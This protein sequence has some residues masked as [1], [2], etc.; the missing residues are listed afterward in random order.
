MLCACSGEHLPLDEMPQSPESLATRD[1]SLSGLSFKN[2]DG[3]SK[4]NDSQQL[5][6]VESALK[7]GLSLNYEEARALLGRLEYQRG[8]FNAALQVFQGIDIGTMRPKMVKAIAERTSLKRVRSKLDNLPVYIMSL[9]SV[10]LLLEALLLKSMSLQELGHFE[11][12]AAECKTILDIV[13]SAW[14]DG[15]PKEIGNE[16]KLKELFHRA[17]DLLPRLWKQ[18]GLL[19]EAIAAYRRAL[20]K[21]WDLSPQRSASLQKDLAISLLYGGAEV[22][23]LHLLQP[24]SIVSPKNNI[25]EAV[26][27]LFILMRKIASEEISGDPEIMNHLTFALSLSGCFESLATYVEQILPGILSRYER[28]YLL[29][30][31]YS[32]AG[33]NDA[34][35]NILRKTF[36]RSEMKKRDHFPSLLLGAKLCRTNPDLAEEGVEFARRAVA[37]ST[38]QHKNQHFI[39]VA[40]HLLGTCYGICSGSSRP[41]LERL[42]LEKES[43]NLLRFAENLVKNDPEIIYSIALVHAKQRNLG[44]ARDYAVRY[45]NMMA[46][47]SV[48][49]WK[50]LAL[51]ASAEQDMKEAEAIVDLSMDEAGKDQLELLRL[52]AV[53]QVAQEEFK[54]AVET[55]MSLLAAIEAQRKRRSWSTNFKHNET[56]QQLEMET[57]LE[58]ALIYSRLG[59]WNDSDICLNK[60]KSIQYFSPKAWHGTGNLLEARSLH[61]EALVAFSMSLSVD[62][63]Y[64]PSMVSTAAVLRMQGDR[65]LPMARSFLMNAVRIDPTNH[66]AWLHLGIVE[67]TEGSLQ[68]AADCFQAAYELKQSSPVMSFL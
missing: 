53:L 2:G 45:L 44:M 40:S 34:A 59:L 43:L 3:E 7:E 30:L 24:S 29:S 32:S 37:L 15:V 49:G 38:K 9:H 6:D 66:D 25:E 5:D 36:C 19:E 68:D 16:C 50:L 12:A 26:F 20:T 11:D 41:D 63:D 4:N 33:L 65:S 57:W 55:Y 42:K 51:V 31:C 23:P 39:G 52:K 58:L 54:D 10:S 18:A 21:P 47:C 48:G 17:L 8:N 22:L 61:K 13:E 60:A 1:F 56:E 35:L 46:G 28:W 62:P 14:S 64:V 67:K 27:L